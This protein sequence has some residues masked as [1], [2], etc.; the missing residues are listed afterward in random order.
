MT[1]FAN[2]VGSGPLLRTKCSANSACPAASACGR[3]PRTTRRS[4]DVG[5]GANTGP[6]SAHS[7]TSACSQE[8]TV[9]HNLAVL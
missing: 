2:R 7:G 8:G 6:K 4:T 9:S 5:F 1:V 3:T